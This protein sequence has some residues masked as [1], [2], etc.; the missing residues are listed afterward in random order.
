M[1]GPVSRYSAMLHRNTS[2]ES[3]KMRHR[4][5]GARHLQADD[6]R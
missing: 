4:G 2:A 1:R 6:A 3:W 5:D